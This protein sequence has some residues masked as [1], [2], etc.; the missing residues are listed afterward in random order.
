MSNAKVRILVVDD[1]PAIR[2]L[3][4]T[5]LETQ[6]FEVAPA[7]SLRD[8]RQ[9]L[10]AEKPHVVILDLGL[11]DGSGIELLQALRDDGD[12]TPVVILSSRSDEEGIV[13]ALDLGADDYVVKPFRVSELIARV[14]AALRHRL[15]EQGAAP[16]FRLGDLTVDLVR[17]TVC[18]RDEN[19]KLSP[20]EY[21]IL[22]LLVQHA[23]KVLTHSYILAQVWEP[24]ADIQYLRVYVRQLRN[25]LGDDLDRPSYIFTE[26]GV[27]YRLR[28]P[29]T[30]MDRK[31]P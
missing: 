8:A 22:S 21:E 11:P 25:K 17:R 15:Q 10:G 13:K 14:R 20:K 27:G 26:T 30:Q 7:G 29:S 5:S 3:L 19:V 18:L 24:D 4:S 1:E 28:D 31:E 12:L 6:D 2:K 9:R 23:G 16:I